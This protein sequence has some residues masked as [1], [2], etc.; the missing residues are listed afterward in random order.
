MVADEEMDWDAKGLL[1]FESEIDKSVSF[2][3]DKYM[4]I[5]QKLFEIKANEMKATF[6]RMVD[7]LNKKYGSN[8]NE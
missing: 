3:F 5:K 6:G 4:D 2:C 1:K 8:P 7:R